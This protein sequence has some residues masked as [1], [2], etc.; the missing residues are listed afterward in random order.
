MGA[1]KGLMG[2]VFGVS[3]GQASHASYKLRRFFAHFILPI[4][5]WRFVF[6]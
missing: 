2:L 1:M 5:L 4:F 6:R 3:W